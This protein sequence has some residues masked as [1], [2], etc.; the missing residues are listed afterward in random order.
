M[1][2]TK[3]LKLDFGYVRVNYPGFPVELGYDYGDFNIA[4]DYDFGPFAMNGRLR[5]S[6]NS[7]GNSGWEWS[8]GR[9]R[10]CCHL[11]TPWRAPRRLRPRRR[12]LR[13]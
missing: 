11:R 10:W 3:D 6:P 2:P 12:G 9:S 1:R 8:R 7:F 4:V 13:S 5:F